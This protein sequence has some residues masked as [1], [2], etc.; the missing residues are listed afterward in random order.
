[1]RDRLCAVGLL[2]LIFTTAVGATPSTLGRPAALDERAKKLA[3]IDGNTL[4]LASG[5]YTRIDTSKG[6][7][8][9]RLHPKQAPH[10]VAHFAALAEGRYEWLNPASG[11]RVRNHYYDGI[12]IHK[13]AAAR[14]FEAGVPATEGRVA[15]DIF[16]PPPENHQRVNFSQ[17]FKL[18]MTRAPLNRVSGVVFFVTASSMPYLNGRHPCFGT[19][20][21]GREV[22]RSITDGR[23]YT[24]G[25]PM[26]A[27]T[28][29]SV[30]VFAAGNPDP[31]P[32]AV[33]FTPVTPSFK[34][35]EP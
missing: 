27:R 29:H 15:P 35:R 13:I 6:T 2:S 18:G 32:E 26:N 25:R 14:Q 7:I 34:R 21:S 11:E 30:R 22:V 28:I 9:A 20:I 1:M 24:N 10:S 31:L 3:T 33:D 8:L 17:P 5:W 12:E 4:A 19:V 23:A 16:I